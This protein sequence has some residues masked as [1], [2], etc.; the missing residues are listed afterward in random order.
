MNSDWCY[1]LRWQQLGHCLF[2]RSLSWRRRLGCLGTRTTTPR[3]ARYKQT[4]RFG[5]RVW[6]VYCSPRAC[7]NTCGRVFFVRGGELCCCKHRW[8][9]L[10]EFICRHASMQ[11]ILYLWHMTLLRA[12]LSAGR[13]ELY[14]HASQLACSPPLTVDRGC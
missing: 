2:S 10:L 4:G 3:V 14:V 8:L 9:L 12:A 11:H 7:L 5:L 13:V 1:S 6:A